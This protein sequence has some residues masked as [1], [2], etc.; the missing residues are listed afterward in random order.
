[1]AQLVP[2]LK[3]LLV[4]GLIYDC[5]GHFESSLSPGLGGRLVCL[6]KF[7]YAVSLLTH[8]I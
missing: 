4:I 6:D 1:M 7:L 8:L 3:T 2:H 5:L